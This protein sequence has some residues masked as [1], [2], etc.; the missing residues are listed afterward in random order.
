MV[1]RLGARGR[2]GERI[3]ILPT[4]TWYWSSELQDISYVPTGKQ[5]R[6]YADSLHAYANHRKGA[7]RAALNAY[8]N[9]VMEHEEFEV[10]DP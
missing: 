1:R 4:G 6:T 3:I 9:H 5:N 2:W 8:R 7:V 10:V